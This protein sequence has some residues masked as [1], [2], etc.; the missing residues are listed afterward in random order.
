MKSK[1]SEHATMNTMWIGSMLGEASNS[2]ALSLPSAGRP[3]KAPVLQSSLTTG[4]AVAVGQIQSSTNLALVL[5]A[6]KVHF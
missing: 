3:S 4:G 1:S 5:L 2:D 6:A